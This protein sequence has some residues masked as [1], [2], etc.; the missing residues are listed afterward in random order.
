[1]ICVS[2]PLFGAALSVIRSRL[3]WRR[4]A[5]GVIVQDLYSRGLRETG[6]T[7][8]LAERIVRGL[9][10]L[11]LRLC[12]SVSVIHDGFRAELV[13]C[14]HVDRHRIR[15]VR[16]WTHVNSPDPSASAA[17][18]AAHGWN[19][20]EVVVVHAGNMGYKQGLENVIAAA[21]LAA[22]VGARARFV[23]LGDGS[24]RASLEQ[25]GAGLPTLEFLDPVAAHEFPAV[26]GAADVLLVNQ[27]PGIAQMSVPSKLTSY[28]KSAKP[29]LAATDS[30]GLTAREL[31][32]SGA[33]GWVPANRPDLLLSEAI[34]LGTNPG[35][36]AEL[37]E[38]G[39]R[40]CAEL[41]SEDAALDLY[42][43]WIH[44]LANSHR[45]AWKRRGRWSIARMSGEHRPGSSTPRETD[46]AGRG[47]T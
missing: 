9:E 21:S 29:I 6:V 13:D 22:D 12:D 15:T 14:L 45:S 42:E 17:F 4:P 1:V 39:L 2:P 38:A 34:R 28:F 46:R 16:N 5:T 47:A 25:I 18:R 7:N 35:L 26:L 43:Q 19:D 3:G 32:S 20:D 36:A 10:S 23:M 8:G 31:A 27:R 40:Y 24:Q 44:D 41:L 30:D 11:T 37:G 33:G